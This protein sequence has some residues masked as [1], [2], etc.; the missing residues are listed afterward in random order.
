MISK[1]KK[2]QKINKLKMQDYNF[3]QLLA[4]EEEKE[5]FKRL[6]DLKK[7]RKANR[8][9]TKG[10]KLSGIDIQKLPSETTKFEQRPMMEAKLIPDHPSSTTLVGSSGSGKTTLFANLLLNK[11]MWKDYFDRVIVFSRTA[12]T[13][14]LYRQLESQIDHEDLIC[15]DLEKELEKFVTDRASECENK[16]V[17]NTKPWLVVFEDLTSEIKLMNSPAFTKMWVQNRHLNLSSC[18]MVHKYK[19]LSRIARM[20]AS[21]IIAFPC[22]VSDVEQMAEDLVVGKLTKKEMMELISFCFEKEDDNQHP[23][24][25]CNNKAPHESRFRKSFSKILKLHLG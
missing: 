4:D 21:N 18:A 5:M 25:Y 19:A 17:E 13:D 3:E 8:R 6:S 24:F 2:N 14:G 15:D 16:G 12:K 7:E 1:K 22:A 11:D 23:F 10:I 9:K 20:Q